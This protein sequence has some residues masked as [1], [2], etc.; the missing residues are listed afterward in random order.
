MS[1]LH[2]TTLSVLATVAVAAIPC[3]AAA[4]APASALLDPGV[5]SQPDPSTDRGVSDAP[6]VLLGPGD[7]VTFTGFGGFDARYSRMLGLNAGVVCVEGGV[8]LNH[9][10][11]LGIGGCGLASY[12]GAEDVAGLSRADGRMEF[13]YG[14]AAIRYHLMSKEVVNVSIGALLGAGTIT[15]DEDT[16]GDDSYTDNVFVFEPQL[17]VHLNVTR[18]MRVAATGGYRLVS[19]VETEGM[20]NGDLS[21]LA[22]GGNVQFG[23]F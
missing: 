19:G 5:P 18:W 23:W 6:D 13:G 17:G 21:N 3:T 2:F 16:Q 20:D 7:R 22:V 4:Q 14:G 15:F 1:R 11:S 12:V 9:A 10:L 8:I